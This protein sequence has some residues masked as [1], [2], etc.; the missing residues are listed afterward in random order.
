MGVTVVA[1]TALLDRSPSVGIRFAAAGIPWMPLLSW[2]DI[3]IEP[4]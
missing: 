1:A 2:D 4:I 3:G